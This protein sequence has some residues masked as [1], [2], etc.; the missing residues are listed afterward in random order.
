MS[1]SRKFV[2][3]RALLSAVAVSATVAAATVAPMATAH[4]AVATPRV[5][6]AASQAGA[7][8]PAAATAVSPLTQVAADGELPGLRTQT[9]RTFRDGD[10]GVLRT[11]VGTGPVNFKDGA[12]AWQPIDD[13]LVAAPAGSGFGW[14]NRADGYLVQF[15]ADLA[16]GP[17]KVTAGS[18]WV[19]LRLAGAHA[20]GQVSGATVTYRDAL[21]GV[22]VA[23]TATATGP[24]ET[25]TLAS[26]AAAAVPFAFTV[27]TS[28]G[29]AGATGLSAFLCKGLTW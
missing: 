28:P 21:P 16:D 19:G 20:V 7:V 9:S 23:Y 8:A 6:S 15:P 26:P 27:T 18:A 24:K 10:A 11:T 25:L 17:V 29:L 2:L 13:S 1:K 14:Q 22:T 3:S 12:G 4:A 5:S